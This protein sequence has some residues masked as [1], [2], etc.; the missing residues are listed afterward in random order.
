M[1]EAGPISDKIL[2]WLTAKPDQVVMSDM[3]VLLQAFHSYATNTE[4]KHEKRT[5]CLNMLE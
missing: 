3:L 5:R 2:V 4:M 1:P